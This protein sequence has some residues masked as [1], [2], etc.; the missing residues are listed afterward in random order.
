MQHRFRHSR[1]L[2][3]KLRPR[4]PS[5]PS[6]LYGRVQGCFRA[7]FLF[8]EFVVAERPKR[9]ESVRLRATWNPPDAVLRPV[10]SALTLMIAIA[11]FLIWRAGFA[12]FQ[13]PNRSNRQLWL[14]ATQLALNG[15]WTPIFLQAIRS[16]GSLPGDSPWR[17][18]SHSTNPVGRSS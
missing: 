9:F 17:S 8:K 10:W 5:G 16:L 6:C 3:T 14:Y 15:M 4:S 13:Q 18:S 7:S 12:G 1:K 2:T 11:G